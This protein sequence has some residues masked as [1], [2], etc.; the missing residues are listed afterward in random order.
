MKLQ[1]VGT[2]SLECKLTRLKR[3]SSQTSYRKILFEAV[4]G[5]EFWT[6]AWM[7]QARKTF[8]FHFYKPFSFKF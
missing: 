8:S 6:N 2:M 1:I 5:K 7:L 4:F 3:E